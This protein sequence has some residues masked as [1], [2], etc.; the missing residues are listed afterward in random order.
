MQQTKSYVITPFFDQSFRQVS[1]K[2]KCHRKWLK[3]NES[4]C[5]KFLKKKPMKKAVLQPFLENFEQKIRFFVARYCSKIEYF[6]TAST[7]IGLDG[8]GN[9]CH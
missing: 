2:I 4:L 1:L 8:H 7:F 9:E 6:V 5:F 3:K